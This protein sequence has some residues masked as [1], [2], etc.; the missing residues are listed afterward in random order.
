ME[1]V[2]DWCASSLDARTLPSA[3]DGARAF[4][5]GGRDHGRTRGKA[6]RRYFKARYSFLAGHSRRGPRAHSTQ[7]GEQ[8]GPQRLG[9]A[10]RQVAHGIAAVGLKAEAFR[11]LT[12]QKIAGDVFAA[13]R[14]S[15]VARLE[16]RQPV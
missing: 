10:D 11:H 6:T 16:R 13:C 4:S 1:S 9:V 2:A 5:F 14:N 7:E 15:H 3:D 12:R 8:F